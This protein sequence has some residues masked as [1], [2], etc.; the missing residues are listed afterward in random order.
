[1]EKECNAE[2]G[3]FYNQIAGFKKN[4]ALIKWGPK[5]GQTYGTY[6]VL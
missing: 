5:L 1:M 2:L 3:K 6:S 4:N